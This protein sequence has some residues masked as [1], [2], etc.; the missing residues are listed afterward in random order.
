MLSRQYL[1]VILELSADL[2]ITATDAHSDSTLAEITE[3]RSELVCL[4][5]WLMLERSRV[6]FK[7][8]TVPLR[9]CRDLAC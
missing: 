6:R 4:A 3:G 7:S 8:F 2:G 5:L 1:Q 9:D